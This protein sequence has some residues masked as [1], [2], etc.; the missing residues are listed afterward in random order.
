MDD[1][2]VKHLWTLRKVNEGLM[3]GLKT[4]LF[5]MEGWDELSPEKTAIHD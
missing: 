5:V 1:E 3:L 2:T 4:A